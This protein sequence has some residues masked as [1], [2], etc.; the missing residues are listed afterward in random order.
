MRVL[1]YSYIIVNQSTGK[2][3]ILKYKKINANNKDEKV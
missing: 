1:C 3:N 2:I